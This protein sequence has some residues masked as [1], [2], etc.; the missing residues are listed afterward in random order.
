MTKTKAV[1]KS[2][3]MRIFKQEK[4]WRDKMVAKAESQGSILHWRKLDDAEYDKQLRIK[5]LEEADEVRVATSREELMAELADIYEVV[6]SLC[7]LHNVSKTEIVAIQDKKRAERGGFAE[8]KFVDKVEHP[9]GSYL[10]NYC[11]AE[12]LK[13][14][15]IIEE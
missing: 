6:D 3:P 13:Y 4:L 12:P 15:E 5:L 1:S 2:S 8:R 7:A 9:E 11:L 14:P 10:A